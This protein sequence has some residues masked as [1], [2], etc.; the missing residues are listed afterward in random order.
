MRN[1][2]KYAMRERMRRLKE[3]ALIAIAWAMPRGVV[4]WCAI[5]LGVHATQGP[6]SRTVVPELTVLD[7]LQ[8]WR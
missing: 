5:R 2:W 7:A 4:Y 1:W 6:Y 3:R 8:R